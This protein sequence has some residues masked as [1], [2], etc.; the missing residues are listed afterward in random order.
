M[1]KHYLV[2]LLFA[3]CLISHGCASI[4]TKPE[5]GAKAAADSLLAEKAKKDLEKQEYEK[6]DDAACLEA[7]ITQYPE[8]VMV[9]EAIERLK[10]FALKDLDLELKNQYDFDLLLYRLNVKNLRRELM[11]LHKSYLAE[12]RESFSLDERAGKSFFCTSLVFT[13]SISL[14]D[15]SSPKMIEDIFDSIISPQL[16]Y[17]SVKFKKRK[18]IGGFS[19]EIIPPPSTSTVAALQFYFATDQIDQYLHGRLSKE[20]FVKA[21]LQLITKSTVFPEGATSGNVPVALPWAAEKDGTVQY[22]RFVRTSVPAFNFKY[23]PT[24]SATKITGDN[25]FEARNSANTRQMTIAVERTGVGWGDQVK[26]QALI[27]LTAESFQKDIMQTMH[28]SGVPKVQY[29]KSAG[30][31]DGFPVYEFLLRWTLSVRR[32]VDILDIPMTT[33][34]RLVITKDHA[35]LMTGRVS[36]YTLGDL[37]ASGSINELKEIFSTLAL[38][39]ETLPPGSEAPP[40]ARKAIPKV[41][42]ATSGSKQESDVALSLIPLGS[43]S[44]NTAINGRFSR[45]A[46]PAFALSYPAQWSIRQTPERISLWAKTASSLPAVD[47]MIA[48]ISGDETEFLES[49]A[50]GYAQTLKKKGSGIDLLYNIPTE[51][52]EGRRAYEFEIRY[53]LPQKDGPTLVRTVYGNVIAKSGYA[54]ILAGETEGAIDSLKETFEKIELPK[55]KK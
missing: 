43:D 38:S 50:K 23:P 41:R 3:C 45:S 20:A 31:M 6:C 33:Y 21:S 48:K 17:L 27:E 39:K 24:W 28:V 35:I 53:K 30:S 36:K 34:G 7:Y 32:G 46:I 49:L 4:G 25:V 26:G 14:A 40:V 13:D 52:Y 19:F 10:I 12:F 9:S 47:I 42:K 18:D 5:S 2:C 54:I 11:D 44:D 55:S 29:A 15:V 1:K 22:G 16:D 37:T 8:S 51:A